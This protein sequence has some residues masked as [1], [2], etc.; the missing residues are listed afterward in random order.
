MVKRR[1]GR[2]LT[3]EIFRSYSAAYTYELGQ[4]T[5]TLR[6]S[7]SY[8]KNVSKI[9]P[10]MTETVSLMKPPIIIFFKLINPDFF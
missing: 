6:G 2:D 1:I 10:D 7:I 3:S 8:L 5:Q 9:L 4:V